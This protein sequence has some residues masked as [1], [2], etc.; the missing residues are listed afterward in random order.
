M[1][2]YRSTFEIKGQNPILCKTLPYVSRTKESD[3]KG[4]GQTRTFRYHLKRTDRL[5]LTGCPS[6]K[7]KSKFI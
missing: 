2:I 7:E 4:N 5:Q 1:S 3:T 6:Q